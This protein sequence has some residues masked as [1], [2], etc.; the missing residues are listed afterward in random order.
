MLDEN[1]LR[2]FYYALFDFDLGKNTIDNLFHK[3]IY[4]SIVFRLYLLTKSCSK[5][6]YE[7]NHLCRKC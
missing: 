2:V 7:E 3:K 1:C 5:M 6:D 4:C